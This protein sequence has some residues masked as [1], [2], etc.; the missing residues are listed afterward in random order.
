[1]YTQHHVGSLKRTVAGKR[2]LPI[3]HQSLNHPG[4]P[5]TQMGALPSA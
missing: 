3:E 2:Q 4:R 1:M 5:K